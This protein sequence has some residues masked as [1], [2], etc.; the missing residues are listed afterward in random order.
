ML[1][2]VIFCRANNSSRATRRPPR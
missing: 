1:R 2:D